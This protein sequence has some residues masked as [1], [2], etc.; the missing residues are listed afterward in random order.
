MAFYINTGMASAMGFGSNEWHSVLS[1]SL[2]NMGWT[3]LDDQS[4]LITKT[5]TSSDVDIGSD[6]ITVS[7]GH[8]FFNGQHIYFIA[9]SGGLPAGLTTATQEYFAIYISSTQFK[10]ASTL[11]NAIAGTPVDLSST[12]GAGPHSVYNFPFRVFCTVAAP[13][14]NQVCKYLVVTS[15]R[16]YTGLSGINVPIQCCLYWNTTTHIG[17]GYWFGAILAL[18]TASGTYYYSFRGNTNIVVL[19]GRYSGSSAWTSFTLDNFTGSS[20]SLILEDPTKSGILTSPA[21][22]GPFITLQL[23]T[24]QA[25]N[26]TVGNYYYIYDFTNHSWVDY[27][28]I[29]ARDTGLDQITVD[30]ISYNYPVGAVLGP[31]PHRFYAAVS[32]SANPFGGFADNFS[33]SQGTGISGSRSAIPYVSAAPGYV[34]HGQVGYIYGAC[35]IDAQITYAITRVDPDDNGRYLVQRPTI[36]EAYRNNSVSSTSGCDRF[37]GTANNIYIGTNTNFS[38]AT[39]TIG[40]LNYTWLSTA[41]SSFCNCTYPVT[42]SV[43]VQNTLQ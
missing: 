38:T 4:T 41:A 23:G 33:Y 8:G 21:T 7:G 14:P 35:S 6:T 18:G 22:S 12:G 1:N 31:Y 16:T 32:T 30:A 20:N 10:V 24:G 5:F 15:M 9:G 26:F 36:Y 42:F 3:L 29:T 25:S 11:L 34:F 28:R 43:I 2:V 27:V 40:G 13:T 17:Y 39:R 19:G 37:Y